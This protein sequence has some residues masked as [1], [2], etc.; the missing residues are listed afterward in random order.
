MDLIAIFITFV[1]ICFLVWATRAVLTAFQIGD[2]W[3]TLIYVALGFL[4]L[5]WILGS[6][7]GATPFLPIRLKHG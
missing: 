2:P 7:S 3:A 5:L 1:V 6:L 4:I